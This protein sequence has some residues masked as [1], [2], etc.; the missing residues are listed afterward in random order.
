MYQEADVSE[1]YSYL[2]HLTA[3][4]HGIPHI[5][6]SCYKR[7]STDLVL[8]VTAHVVICHNALRRPV[9]AVSM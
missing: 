9:S 3:E 4:T 7:I 2:H 8:C 6:P 5:R 1:T